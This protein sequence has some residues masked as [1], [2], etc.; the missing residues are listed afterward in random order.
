MPHRYCG[1]MGISSLIFSPY[2]CTRTG[3]IPPSS[4]TCVGCR[5]PRGRV[6]GRLPH[7]RMTRRARSTFHTDVLACPLDCPHGP[8]GVPARLS[9]RTS[10]RARST[11]HMETPRGQPRHEAGRD[12]WCLKPG[13]QH[14][15]MPGALSGGAR[16]APAASR[17]DARAGTGTEL[18]RQIPR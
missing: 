15:G 2:M 16:G 14:W 10:R 5:G 4:E 6:R 7:D 1:I 9:T 8:P 18:S 17:R 3:T 12:R 13:A 11:V